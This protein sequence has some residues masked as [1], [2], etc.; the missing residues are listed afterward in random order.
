[1][2]PC[3]LLLHLCPVPHPTKHPAL[4]LACLRQAF[5]SLLS[6]GS[7]IV[8]CLVILP[9]S[10]AC[11]EGGQ[12]GKGGVVSIPI[13]GAGVEFLYYL[14]PSPPNTPPIYGASAINAYGVGAVYGKKILNCLPPPFWHYQ[15][16]N[17]AAPMFTALFAPACSTFTA[18]AVHSAPQALG[19]VLSGWGSPTTAKWTK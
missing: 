9:S 7:P 15:N 14:T 6:H 3:L 10:I 17:V 2:P 18:L 12:K 8:C 11:R 1:M 13:G 19:K 16:L 4:H 5:H